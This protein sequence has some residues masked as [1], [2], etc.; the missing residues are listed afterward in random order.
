MSDLRAS[1]K[2]SGTLGSSQ[3]S[4][5]QLGAPTN[6]KVWA[7]VKVAFKDTG[8]PIFIPCELR[9]NTTG[10][11][12]GAAKT[13]VKDNALD[14]ETVQTTLKEYSVQ[15]SN[16]GS[17]VQSKP[18][19]SDRD[20]AFAVQLINGGEELDIWVNPAS[21]TITYEVEVRIQE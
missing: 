13:W 3:I 17:I 5:G 2:L 9:R 12:L 11:T 6:Q 19:R 10:G 15:P 8:T 4:L 1:Y 14:T 21:G 20:H 18:V 7:W 16:D